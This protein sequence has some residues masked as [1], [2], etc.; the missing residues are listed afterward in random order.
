MIIKIGCCGFP[1]SMKKYFMKFKLVEIQKTFYEPPKTETL[2]KWREN[3]PEKFEFS[4]KAWQ[5]LTH[6]YSS[7]TWRKMKVTLKNKENYGFLKPTEENFKAWEKTLE[8]CKALKAKIC[9]I[10]TPPSFNCIQE[11]IQNM[12]SFLNSIKRDEIKIA[13]EPRGNWINHLSEVKRLCEKLDLTHIVDPLKREP[14]V[15]KEVQYFRLHGLHPKK[16]VN[17]KYQYSIEDLRKLY[18]KIEILRKSKVKE[19]YVLFNNLTMNIDAEKF[20]EISLKGDNY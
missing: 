11:N 16:E 8:A 17:Y 5:V 15:V 3:A 2:I 6:T 12:E 18:Y 13:W 7:P 19:V 14:V 20:L 4:V 1:I 9:V 10:Q